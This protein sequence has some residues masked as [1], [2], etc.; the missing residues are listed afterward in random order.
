LVT[1]AEARRWSEEQ[2][3][4]RS[5]RVWAGV[6]GSVRGPERRTGGGGVDGVDGVARMGSARGGLGSV[7]AVDGA[8]EEPPRRQPRR[9]ERRVIPARAAASCHPL[10]RWRRR[11]WMR[12]CSP[13]SGKRG[14]GMSV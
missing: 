8:E 10:R 3:K 14:E 6:A 12:V 11:R 1:V 2:E 4:V 9:E 13:L 7:R 5:V